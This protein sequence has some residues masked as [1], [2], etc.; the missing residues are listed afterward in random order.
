MDKDEPQAPTEEQLA[1]VTSKQDAEFAKWESDFPEEDLT[2]K[3][4]RDDDATEKKPEDNPGAPAKEDDK[5]DTQE[6]EVAEYEAPEPVLIAEDPGEYVPA[7]YSFEITLKDGKTVTVKTPE[8]ADA[9]ADDPDNFETPKQLSDFLKKSLTMSSKLDRDYEKW[10]SQHKTFTEQV[11]QE[12]ERRETVNNYVGEFDYL[13]SKGLIPAVD[14]K[15]LTADWTDP[16]VSKQ[17]GVKEQLELLTYMVEE[18]K[19]RAKA[20]VKPLTSIVD[21]YNAWKA[22]E[23]Q[24]AATDEAKAEAAARK[25]ASAR[26]SSGSPASQGTYVPKGISVGRV[27]PQRGAAMWDD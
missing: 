16:E 24:Q 1:E 10:E 23:K 14:K 20:N 6:E 17:A 9:I 8:E 15:Y 12:S 4:K 3:Y 11:E 26:V 2:I 19:L 21:T 25:A 5:K 22:D 13:V 18:N 7:D 27:I